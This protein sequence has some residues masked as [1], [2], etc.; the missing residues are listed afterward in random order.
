MIKLLIKHHDNSNL[1]LHSIRL[2]ISNEKISKP[3]E[4]KKVLYKV[5]PG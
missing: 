3:V 2:A 5:C 1:I 4:G